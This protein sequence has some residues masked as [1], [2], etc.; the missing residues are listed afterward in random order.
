MKHHVNAPYR[1]GLSSGFTLVELL[2]SI[3]IITTITGLSLSAVHRIRGL[4]DRSKCHNNLRQI[5][6]AFHDSH[7]TNGFFPPGVASNLNNHR[8]PFASWCVFLLPFLD[9]SML[10]NQAKDAFQADPD[11]QHIPPHVGQ[12]LVVPVFVC[13][14]DARIRHSQI[15]AEERFERAFTSYLGVIG[16]N[17]S[18]KDGV[19]Y[20]DSQTSIKDITDGTSSTIM[21]GERP[22]SADLILG[23]WYAGWG[24]D[25]TGEGDMLLGTRTYNSGSN[26]LGCSSGPYKYMPGKIDNQCDAFHF[27][28]LHEGGATFLFC[29]GSVRHVSY[30][31]DLMLLIASTRAGAEPVSFSD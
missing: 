21:V 15:V 5:G 12:K 18:L 26:G 6:L 8:M 31:A 7:I 22:P 24:Q 29:D 4:S 23:W 27:W 10:W 3:A 9:Q 25:R 1:M 14:S 17:S 2:V 30:A 16:L 20:I 11:F 19:L 13:P 28:S